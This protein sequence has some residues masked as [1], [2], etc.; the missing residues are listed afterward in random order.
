MTRLA[1]VAPAIVDAVVEGRAPAGL[2]LQML[3]TTAS[4]CRWNGRIKSDYSN[5]KHNSFQQ[6][7]GEFARVSPSLVAAVVRGSFRRG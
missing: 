2:N 5:S 6:V 4:S 7:Q 1:F 3:W